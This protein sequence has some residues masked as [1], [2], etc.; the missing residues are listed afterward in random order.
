MNTK[1]LKQWFQ[2]A[3]RPLPWRED[4]DPYRVWVSEVMLQ[5]TQSTVVIP[6]FERW[7][8]AFPDIFALARANEREVMK[9]WEGLGYYSRARNLLNGAREVVER[10][11]GSI[12]SDPEKLATIRGIGPY[13]LGAIL[14]FAFQKRAPATDGN[15]KRVIARHFAIDEDIKKTAGL[16]KIAEFHNALL[17]DSEPWIVNEALIELGAL[18][19]KKEPKCASCPVK[20]SCKALK[21]GE[22]KKY[23]ITSKRVAI[24]SLVRQV[25]VIEHGGQLLVREG[26]RGQIMEG[27]IEFPWFEEESALKKIV[28]SLS[29]IYINPLPEEKQTF[30]RFKVR[31][32]PH[33]YRAP[34]REAIEGYF[35]QEREE[36][37]ELPLSSGHKRIFASLLAS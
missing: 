24:T 7:M 11:G 15:V 8:K 5:Q 36:L 26:A 29:C 3:A 17:E 19:C 28:T 31:L 27:L 4:R 33:L 32:I 1:Q 30:T 22:V 37:Q 25:A 13:T 6:Y 35:W 18:V 9:L 16:R 2:K 12:P 20:P 34:K 23:P 14:S 10:F 21:L